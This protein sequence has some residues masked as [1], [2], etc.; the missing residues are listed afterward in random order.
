ML[1]LGGVGIIL[2]IGILLLP[3]SRKLM[4]YSA[5]NLADQITRQ[6]ILNQGLNQNITP[7]NTNSTQ[8]PELA[9]SDKSNPNGSGSVIYKAPKEGEPSTPSSPEPTGSNSKISPKNQPPE[10]IPGDAI[11]TGWL[12][13]T[14]KPWAYVFID[15]KS[16]GETPLKDQ[17]QLSVG[18]HQITFSHSAFPAPVVES[19]NIQ[20]NET[21]RLD[22]DLWS[23]FAIVKVVSVKPWAYVFIN[24]IDYG[25]A[26]SASPI[27]LPWGRYVIELRNPNF[28]TWRSDVSLTKDNPTF[29]INVALER[30]SP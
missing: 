18:E 2:L 30:Q 29:E 15:D 4:N 21:Q 26:S 9:P 25:E 1:T 11:Q 14:T 3:G 20:S 13:I 17:I 19:V 7:T 10:Q 23:Y 6:S 8:I 16:Y 24:G 22:V 27:I 5:R 12:T 28:V